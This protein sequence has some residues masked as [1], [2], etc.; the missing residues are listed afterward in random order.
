[1]FK[2][3]ISYIKSPWVDHPASVGETYLGHMKASMGIALKCLII[4]LALALHS[5]F[6]FI[7]KTY[8]CDMIKS[9]NDLCESRSN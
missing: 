8:G 4:S 5:I 2:K 6:P 3:I 1:M 9:L 7:F